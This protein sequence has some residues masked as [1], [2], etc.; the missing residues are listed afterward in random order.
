MFQCLWLT[1]ILQDLETNFQSITG[2]VIA[3]LLFIVMTLTISLYIISRQPVSNAPLSFRVP[4]VPWLPGFSIL[5]N[6]YLMIK[7]DIITWIRFSVWILIGLLIYFSYS[8]RNSRLRNKE[9]F[10]SLPNEESQPEDSIEPIQMQYIERHRH[11]NQVPL[12]AG[13]IET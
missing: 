10:W 2:G 8:I 13:Q 5:I 6:V 3:V 9:M 11:F 7:L 4:M 1:Y 12:M